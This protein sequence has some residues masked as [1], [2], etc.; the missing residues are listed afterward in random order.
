MKRK[1]RTET[2]VSEMS[3]EKKNVILY[4]LNH[5]RLEVILTGFIRKKIKCER[6]FAQYHRRNLPLF[7]LH[8]NP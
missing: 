6:Y 4:L 1:G 5:V 2:T 8:H 3:K 7:F